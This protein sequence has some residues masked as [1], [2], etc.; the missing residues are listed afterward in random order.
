MRYWLSFCDPDRP[1]G[2]QFLGACI[3]EVSEE[4]DAMG[5]SLAVVK[6]HR[7]GCNPGGEVLAV[8][9]DNHLII[10]ESWLNRVLSREDCD[11]F[12]SETRPQNHALS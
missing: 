10:A 8:R 5:E 3:V 9:I 7:M 11:A 6:A 12:D 1:R 4:R 2:Q